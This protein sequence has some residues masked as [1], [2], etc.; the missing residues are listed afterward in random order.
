MDEQDPAK[1]SRGDRRVLRP[2]RTTAGDGDV[3][4]H[5]VQGRRTER[6]PDGKPR[7]VVKL[8]TAT[9]RHIAF[10]I[11]IAMPCHAMP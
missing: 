8:D 1:P 5:E 2:V 4:T 10:A 3:A 7:E 9:E 6:D 11:A